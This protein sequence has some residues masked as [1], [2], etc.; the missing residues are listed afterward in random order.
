MKKMA[1]HRL[2][3]MAID[4]DNDPDLSSDAILKKFL[5]EWVRATVCVGIVSFDN[6]DSDRLTSDTTK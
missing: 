3:P 5:A 4:E 6:G 1:L 2:V